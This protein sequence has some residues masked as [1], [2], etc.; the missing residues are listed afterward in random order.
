MGKTRLKWSRNKN[1]YF[2]TGKH[3]A[4]YTCTLTLFTPTKLTLN[5]DDDDNVLIAS[6]AFMQPCMYKFMY[7][8][9]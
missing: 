7:I 5:N 8:A 9:R 6:Y 3:I 2:I 1:N 4:T